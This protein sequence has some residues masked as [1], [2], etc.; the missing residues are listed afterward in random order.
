MIDSVTSKT[1]Q[2]NS[3]SC[4][5]SPVSEDLQVLFLNTLLLRYPLRATVLIFLPRSL[6]PPSLEDETISAANSKIQFLKYP[7]G[8]QFVFYSGN[9]VMKVTGPI[10][11]MVAV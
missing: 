8:T 9:T 7:L 4:N 11:R 2:L 6:S 1:Q 3:C 5:S 10:I